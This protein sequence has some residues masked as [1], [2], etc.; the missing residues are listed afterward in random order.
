MSALGFLQA[1]S[2]FCVYY[3]L[4]KEIHMDEE[5][6]KV[7]DQEANFLDRKTSI[8]ILIVSMSIGLAY[9]IIIYLI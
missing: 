9:T 7:D 6:K 3:G 1:R 8:N 5:E 2:S 4:K